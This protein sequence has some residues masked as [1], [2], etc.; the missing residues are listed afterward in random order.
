MTFLNAIMLLGLAA[1]AIPIIIHILNR[2]QAKVVA[3]GAMH[4]LEASLASRNRRILIEEIVLMVIRCL[5]LAALAFALARP[6]VKGRMLLANT[7]D[8]QD[9]AVVLDGSMSMTL[10][11]AGKSNFQ[12]AVEEAHQLV[13]ACRANDASCVLL[14]GPAAQAP[15]PGPVSDRQAVHEV[16]KT[17]KPVGGTMNVPEALQAAMV[18][19]ANGTNPVKKIV[20]I[21]DGQAVGWELSA[22]Q[23]WAFLAGAAQGLPTPPAVV[24][25]TLPVPPQWRNAQVAGLTLSRSVVGTDRPVRITVTIANTGKGAITPE[26]VELMIDGKSV[27]RQGVPNVAEGASASVTFDHQFQLHGPH[28]VSAKLLGED[29]L[30]GD[31]ELVRVVD[32]QKTLPVLIIEGDPSPRFLHGDADYLRVALAPPPEQGQQAGQLIVPKVVAAADIASVKDFA[33][34]DVTILANVRRLPAAVANKL[35]E[36]AAEGGLMVAL[37]ESADREF[38]NNWKAADGRRVLGCQLKEMRTSQRERDG[39]EEFARV[40]ANTVLHPALKLLS[41]PAASD[42]AAAAIKRYWVLASD[43]D[44]PLKPGL[45]STGASLNNGDPCLLQRRIERGVVLTLA[46]S[47]DDKCSDLPKRESYVPLVHE[48]LYYVAARAQHPGNVLPGETIACTIPGKVTVDRAEVVSPDGR[49]TP[50]KLKQH[51][52]NWMASFPFTVSPGLYRLVLPD[53]ALGELATRPAITTSAY[54]ST[55]AAAARG[56]PFIV[57]DNPDE[58]RL[59]P[60]G[61]DDYRRAGQY[62]NLV[63]AEALSEAVAAI[64]G[65]VPGGEI[66]QTLAML[67][68]ALLLAEGVTT[69]LIALRRKAH[70]AEAVAFGVEQIDAEA[71]RARARETLAISA[72]QAQG[73]SAP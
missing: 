36:A 10:E 25:R 38:Y 51:A 61:R 33:E 2:R 3:W 53:E 45:V 64:S 47:L 8:A 15:I 44:D 50:I 16:L 27:E 26:G 40:A 39:R 29:D 5:A 46:F 11:T 31:N 55:A 4:F 52:G 6:F 66:W 48:L 69:R 62:L 57:M 18:A 71:F 9:V 60:L 58:S 42:L 73:V 23:R 65:G 41:D 17:L 67:L 1:V 68:L 21:T 24:V 13:D 30:A 7:G 37:G 32:V 49:R 28:L 56:I 43:P 59:E 54:A 72:R 70:L 34:Y 19:L 35:A 12:R 22:Q 14:A 20:L 63:H